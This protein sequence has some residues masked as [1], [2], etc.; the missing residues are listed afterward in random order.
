VALLITQIP[1]TQN[2]IEKHL[3]EIYV[4]SELGKGATFTVRLPLATIQ[5]NQG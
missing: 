5:Q 1:F 3:G 4:D 2:I